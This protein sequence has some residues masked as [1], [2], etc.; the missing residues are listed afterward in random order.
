MAG[1]SVLVRRLN[2]SPRFR[3]RKPNNRSLAKEPWREAPHASFFDGEGSIGLDP[4]AY[5]VSV[6]LRISQVDRRVLDDISILLRI[7]GA[8]SR[9]YVTDRN[10]RHTIHALVVTSNNSAISVLTLMIPHLRVKFHQ[11]EVTLDYLLEK[12]TGDQFVDAMNAEVHAGR[13]AGKIYSVNQPF[14]HSDGVAMVWNQ[15]MARARRVFREMATT[16]D[17]HRRFGLTRLRETSKEVLKGR[18][19]FFGCSMTVTKTRGQSCL[20]AALDAHSS[21][22]F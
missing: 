4:R 7:H 8:D 3:K 16:S 17:G 18:N 2:G 12:I 15:S 14:T 22:A 5:S 10:R 19:R 20:G 9:V 13:R 6:S 1:S 11:A 21:G